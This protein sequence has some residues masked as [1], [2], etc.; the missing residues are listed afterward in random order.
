MYV[1]LAAQ[2]CLLLC[3]PSKCNPPR[4]SV[5]GILQAR[6]LEWVAV[7]SSSGFSQPR[8]R[9]QVFC[10]AGRLFIVIFKYKTM[11]L[12]KIVELGK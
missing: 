12:F 11:V 3:D 2:S 9:T 7:H 5:H 8:Y 4:S 10:I 1:C 6:I